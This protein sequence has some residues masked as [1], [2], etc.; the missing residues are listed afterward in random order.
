MT[1]HIFLILSNKEGSISY[2]HTQILAN[3]FLPAIFLNHI[4]GSRLELNL[5]K[6]MYTSV[7]CP[8]TLSNLRSPPKYRAYNLDKGNPYPNPAIGALKSDLLKSGSR[9]CDSAVVYMYVQILGIVD[10]AIPHPHRQF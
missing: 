10:R 7:P 3:K 1:I 9:S 4:N 2:K 6:F 5:F 8:S